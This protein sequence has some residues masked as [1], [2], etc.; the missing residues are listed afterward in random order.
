MLNEASKIKCREFVTADDVVKGNY[1]LN[2]AFVANLFNKFPALPEPESDEIRKQIFFL[3]KKYY[4]WDSIQ[5]LF[6]LILAE[7]EVMEE[8]RE[9]KTY[10][11]WMNSLGVDPYVN[12]LYSDLQ[13]GLVIFQVSYLVKVKHNTKFGNE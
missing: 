10:R 9:E 1:K 2:L 12:Y 6:P 11:N 4:L 8:T 7:L 5:N 13:N 3:I